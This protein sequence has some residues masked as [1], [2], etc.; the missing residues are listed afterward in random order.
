MENALSTAAG[1]ND[2]S[3]EVRAAAVA[4]AENTDAVLTAN[5][6]L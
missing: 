5:V 4:A 6:Y 2:A 1:E 3:V